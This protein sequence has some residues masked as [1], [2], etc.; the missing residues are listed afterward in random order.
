MSYFLRVVK[1]KNHYVGYFCVVTLMSSAYLGY[2]I[3]P[4]VEM[5]WSVS[6]FLLERWRQ[7]RHPG[8]APPPWQTL[9]EASLRSWAWTG[10]ANRPRT[11]RTTS[12][13]WRWPTAKALPFFDKSSPRFAKCLNKKWRRARSNRRQ[14]SLSVPALGPS[15]HSNYLSFLPNFLPDESSIKK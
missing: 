1:Y 12:P 9:G 3:L 14:S 4:W 11:S 2:E 6:A 8:E 5:L 13:G 7:R 15:F 10:V